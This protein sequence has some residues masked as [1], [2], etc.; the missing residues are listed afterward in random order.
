MYAQIAENFQAKLLSIGA[1]LITVVVISGS[2]TDPVNVPKLLALG[3]VATASVGVSIFSTLRVR[4]LENKFA[5]MSAALFMIALFNSVIFSNSPLTQNIYG[6]YG[7]NN[8]IL[9]YVFLTF[10]FLGGLTLRE[11]FGF[12][13]VTTALIV[14]GL[15]NLVYCLWVIVFGDFVGWSNPYGNI[16]G[17]F[18]NPNFIGSFLGM[19]FA[20][21]IARLMTKPINKLYS[22]SAIVIVPLTAFA[23]IKSHAIQGRVVA[24]M[25]LVIVGFYFIRSRYSNLSLIGYSL[26][27]MGGGVFALLGA[28]QIGPLTAFIYKTSVS[29]R[30]QYWL[31]GWNT[32]ES[33]PLTGV[34]MDAFGDWYR[35]SRDEHALGL[36]GV[37]TV[38]NA[39][40]NVPLDMFAFG[41]WPLFLTY[42]LIVGLTVRAIIR[43]TFRQKT[44]DPIFVSL[45]VAWFGYQL[46]SIISI[47]Q[48]GLAIWGWIL[49]GCLIAYDTKRKKSMM[50]ES[51]SVASRGKI[52]E[53]KKNSQ[54]LHLP[55]VATIGGIA[56]LIIALP[57]YSAD[58][59]WRSA[60]LTQTAAPLEESLQFS[61]FNPL[62][63]TKYLTT[64]QI[65]E[66]NRL[67]DLAHKSALQAVKWNPEAFELW[68]VLY[69]LQ[70]TTPEERSLALANMKRL[71]PLNPDVTAR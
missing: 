58:S 12:R 38:V 47:N 15:V 2:V 37:N 61:Y 43:T 17:T 25:G 34:G 24:V 18:G 65:F 31:A 29:L 57:P 56:G 42:L 26:A 9:T 27:A 45:T 30:G 44:Y 66:E 50:D 33:H 22:Y 5:V 46:Q 32:G 70:Q 48:I 49:S 8:G 51:T 13:R 1:I 68:K 60:Q 20:G 6:A 21:Y 36:P 64:I 40:H 14:A 62:N 11:D 35:R 54:Q 69:L 55:L 10:L 59:K 53:S 19:F 41:G 39:A 28:L 52:V 23:I 4:L 7:R 63:S 71:D 16:L 3:I 67:F